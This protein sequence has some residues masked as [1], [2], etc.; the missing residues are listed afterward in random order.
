MFAK[1]CWIAEGAECGVAGFVRRHAGGDILGDLAVEVKCQFIVE[2]CGG[3]VAAEEHQ[4]PHSKLFKPAH[5]FLPWGWE[6]LV[7][8]ASLTTR[9][10]AAESR[11]QFAVSFSS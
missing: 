9:L 7:A 11:F 10:M 2:A 8:Q 3:V 6:S 4:G 1:H 5:G